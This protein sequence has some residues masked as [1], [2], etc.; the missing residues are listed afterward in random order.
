MYGRFY[1]DATLHAFFARQLSRKWHFVFNS[2]STWQHGNSHLNTQLQYH[3]KKCFSEIAYTSDSH[4]IGM[5]SLY[6]FK[7][8]GFLQLSLGGELYF[9]IKEMGGGVSFGSRAIIQDYSLKDKLVEP[10]VLTSTINPIMGHLSIASSTKIT[11]H[12]SVANCFDFN[13]YNLESDVNF[14]FE[15]KSADHALLKMRIGWI[16]GLSLIYQV[17]MKSCIFRIGLQT[18]LK[19]N[20]SRAFNIE[21]TL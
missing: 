16:Q 15:Y 14:G 4:L 3:G 1:T 12:F 18:E 6:H 5:R 9:R 17:A 8:L 21:L 7:K 19:E 10:L 13:L 2:V 20:G 11:N